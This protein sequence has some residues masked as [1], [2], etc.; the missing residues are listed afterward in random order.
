MALT[1]SL[2][3]PQN[4]TLSKY[5]RRASQLCTGPFLHWSH[6]SRRVTAKA[7]R[8]EAAA[9]LAPEMASSTNLWAGS[10]L[11]T[12]S[13]WNPGWLTSTKRVT[14]WDQ[15]P[16]GDTCHTGDSALVEHM[17][18]RSAGTGLVIKMHG[19]PWT[20]HSPSTW[21][22][23]LLGPGK[24]TKCESVPLWS[25]SEPEWFRPGKW[26]EMQGP[27]WAMLLQSTM[28]PEQYRPRKHMPP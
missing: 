7:R 15:L 2:A 4:N 9:I 16:R 5:Q 3:H 23:D 12:M 18:Y 20:V 11:L 1:C 28:E 24:E 27:R 19:P 26:H 17:G 25:T 10:Q 22:S 14:A 13:S 21:S 6:S 8:Q